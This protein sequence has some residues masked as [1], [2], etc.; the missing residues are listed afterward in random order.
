MAGYFTK[1]RTIPSD[2]RWDHGYVS[3][4]SQL[5]LHSHTDFTPQVTQ[6]TTSYSTLDRTGVQ[7]QREFLQDS[8][9]AAAAQYRSLAGDTGHTFSTLKREIIYPHAFKTYSVN[10]TGG[11][12]YIHSPLLVVESSQLKAWPS[13]PTIDLNYYGTK[14]IKATI[15]TNPIAGLATFTGELHQFPQ[16]YGAALLKEKLNMFNALG[17]EYLNV[18]FGWA[19]FV[20]DLIKAGQSLANAS[21]SIRQLLRDSGRDV[22]RQYEFDPITETGAVTNV[23]GSSASIIPSSMA[24]GNYDPLFVNGG[25]SSPSKIERQVILKRK[26]WFSGKYTY[27]LPTDMNNVLDRLVVYE[28][29][30]NKLLGTRITPSV[31]YNLTPWTWLADWFANIGDIVSNASSLQEDNLVLRYGYLMCESTQDVI[32]TAYGFKFTNY[33]P[34]PLVTSFRQTRKERIRATPFGFGLN[35]A[36]FDAR[37]WAILGALALTKTP[38]SLK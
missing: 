3:S 16:I 6:Q 21:A 30:F 19:P 20:S 8:R 36:S 2:I 22:R 32:Y 5:N 27:F 18:Q 25:R 4:G 12:C 15:P 35:P 29:L 24:S 38:T 37:Q 11:R 28:A 26:I 23:T 1:K 7:S 13:I 31:L 17:K 14:A 33:D 10:V 34:G 9:E